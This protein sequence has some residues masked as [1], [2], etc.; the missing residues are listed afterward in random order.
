[1]SEP[2]EAGKTGKEKILPFKRPFNP[3]RD[4]S[5]ME[6]VLLMGSSTGSYGWTEFQAQMQA[7]HLDPERLVPSG[8]QPPLTSEQAASLRNIRQN[9][10]DLSMDH[11][12][13]DRIVELPPE[14]RL[15]IQPIG[16]VDQLTG[17]PDPVYRVSI[18]DKKTN[19]EIKKQELGDLIEP[20]EFHEGFIEIVDD[21]PGS[22]MM[23]LKHELR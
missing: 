17:V 10:F 13:G 15:R 8:W 4:L 18:V 20:S 6:K 12:F 5:D 3:Q 9:Q 23:L 2:G 14:Y 19:E 21:E 1:M 22:K 16:E 11:L 7:K